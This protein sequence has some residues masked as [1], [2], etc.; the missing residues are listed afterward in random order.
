MKRSSLRSRSALRSRLAAILGL[1]VGTAATLQAAPAVVTDHNAYHPGEPITAYF[2]GGPGNRLDWV[3]VYPEDVLPGSV[4]STV[5]RYVNNTQSGSIGFS[6]GS[7]RY[8]AGLSFPGTWSIYFL[9][10]DSYDILAQSKFAVVEATAPLAR[11]DKRLYLPAEAITITF[12][13]GPANKLDWIGLYKEGQTPGAVGSTAYRYVDGTQ[14]GVTALANGSV[15]FASGLAGPGNWV[16]YFLENDGFTVLASEVFT[17]QAAAG[18]PPKVLAV[19]PTD[20]S[21]NAPPAPI[22]F[23]TLQAGGAPIVSASIDLKLDGTK[24]A[25]ESL[26]NA[27]KLEVRYNTDATL[28]AGSVHQF[29]LTFADT[30][31]A[32]VTNE[33]TFTIGGYVDIQLPAPLFLETF[34]ALSE[35]QL[36][37]GWTTVGYS[38]P[39]NDQV[40]FGDL[41]SVAYQAWAVVNANRFNGTFKTYGNPDSNDADYQRVLRV[42]PRIVVN[43]KVLRQP[44]AQGRFLFGNSGYQNGASS[45]VVFAF[46]GDYNLTGKTDIHVSFHSLYEQNQDSIGSLEYSINGGQSWLPVVYYLDGPDVVRNDAGEV[47]AD[48]TLNTERSDVARYTDADGTE[49]GGTYGAFLAAP[50]SPALAPFIQ[51]RVNDN[52]TEGKRIELFRLAQADN[53]K[54]VRF[55]FAYAGTDSWYW[56]VDD[57]GLYSISGAAPLNLSILREGSGLK[58]S[59]TGGGAGA[60]LESA[61]SL[62]APD[63]QPIA[64]VVGGAVTVSPDAAQRYFRVRQP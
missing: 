13:N 20:K 43:G 27:D 36:P 34:D 10:N 45:Q 62:S 64:G 26:L 19:D 9:L 58:V 63:W 47:D 51:V 50:F 22:Y 6:E 12:T 25:H 48:A 18:S 59:W 53:Q 5:W 46:T 16:A 44:L 15:T 4:G 38:G 21:T 32:R 31:G 3:A 57:F 23:A 29:T 1:L 7:V 35:G 55:R 49:L 11:S 2:S 41:S 56:G 8:P 39:L 40:D 52:P 24:V 61:S 42:N 28:P 30:A 37:A 33:V 14:S 60:V 54:T 17:V